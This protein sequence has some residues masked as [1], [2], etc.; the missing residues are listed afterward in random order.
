MNPG[1]FAVLPEELLSRQQL[2]E[3]TRVAVAAMLTNEGN[4]WTITEVSQE[5]VVR[6]LLPVLES[7]LWQSTLRRLGK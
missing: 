2:A 5:E 1:W 7:F 6:F 4:E 3:K